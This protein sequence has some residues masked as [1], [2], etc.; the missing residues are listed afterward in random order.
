MSNKIDIQ[1]AVAMLHA[2]GYTI[3]PPVSEPVKERIDISWLQIHDNFKGNGSDSF[4]YQF[5][6]SKYLSIS[7]CSKLS[8]KI[9][10]ALNDTVVDDN[11][12]VA[13]LSLND[14]L[15]VWDDDFIRNKR[16]DVRNNF[17]Q[18]PM[19]KRFQKLAKQKLNQ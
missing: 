3:T 16:L 19:Y 9:E 1:N 8:D 7:D 2:E 14:L 18:S 13:C 17:M 5:C 4:W 10:S 11:S 15:E 6:S 12:D